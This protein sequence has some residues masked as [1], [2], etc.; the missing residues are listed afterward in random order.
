M[1]ASDNNLLMVEGLSVRIQTAGGA[2]R[3]VERVSFNVE[4]GKTLAIV[5]ES[6]SG[7]SMLCRAVMGILP[8]CAKMPDTTRILFDGRDLATLPNKE[9]NRIRGREVGIV[10]QNPLSSLNPVLTVA[11]Q[12]TEPMQYHL[13]ISAVEAK[14]RALDLLQAV[15]IAQPEQRLKCHPHQ[16]SGGMRQRVAI[17]I[18]L[19]CDPRLLI[20]DEP[21]TALDVTVQAEIL[22]LLGRLQKE[23]GMAMILVTHDLGVVAGRA[24][25]TA[26]MYAGRVVE[27]APTI[28]LFDKMRMHYTQA[29]FDAIPRLDDLPHKLLKDIGGQPPNLSAMLAGCPFAP[30]CARAEQRCREEEPPLVCDENEHHRYACWFPRCVEQRI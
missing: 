3:A 10:L 12:I 18:A 1:T 8:A 9:L 6:G 24:H 21:T 30:R 26:V 25:D 11:K 17:A 7:K 16:L 13:G 19:A 4:R 23:R 20:A 27:H 15:G 22:N 5:G 29:L 2:V 14:G 28:D